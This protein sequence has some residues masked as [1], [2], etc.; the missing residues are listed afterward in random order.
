MELTST[1]IEKLKKDLGDTNSVEGLM[2]KG[3]AIKNLLKTLLETMY[4]AELTD[5]LGY[6]KHSPLGNNTGNSRN[7]SS[8]KTLKSD[9]GEINVRV[10]RDRN[11]DYQ[12]AL[13]KKYEKNIGPIEEKV[14]S[15]YARGMSTRDIQ[16][17]VEEIYGLEISPSM[18]SNITDKVLETVKEWQNRPLEKIYPIMFFDA[19]HFKVRS[20]GKVISKAAYTCLAI[21]LEGHKDM[22]GIWIGESEGAH[23]WLSVFTELSNRGVQDIL[24]TCVDGLKGFPDAINSVFP[25][26]VTQL[27]VIHAIRNIIRRISARDRPAFMKDL[28]LVYKAPTLEAAE[29]QIDNL[30][31]KWGKKYSSAIKIWREHWVNI[32]HYL[33]YPE[34]LRKIIYTTN[35]VEALHR[36]F[37]KV[38]KTKSLF[39]N[40][41]SLRKILY[42]SYKNIAEK[43][44]GSVSKWQVILNQLNIIFNDRLKE[45]Y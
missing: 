37:R 16:A 32:S 33:S 38:T 8:K 9:V 27:C 1:M 42:L 26:A 41:E 17:H 7:G 44:K 28:Q 43:W 22:L 13:I 14:I 40:D 11:G 35:P 3:G 25:R 39:P 19:I 20:E 2:G 4:E 15:M 29:L 24:I 12:P 34:E 6:D 30:D 36:Q 23:F 18:V 5:H 21:D 10:P 45:Y 31:R